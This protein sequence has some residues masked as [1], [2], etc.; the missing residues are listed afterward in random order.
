M[1]VPSQLM[2]DYFAKEL[3]KSETV[4]LLHTYSYITNNFA[5][6]AGS[7]VFYSNVQ[8]VYILHAYLL[9]H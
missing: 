7:A 5:L 8:N 9:I 2:P 3:L 6:L 4:K 1:A